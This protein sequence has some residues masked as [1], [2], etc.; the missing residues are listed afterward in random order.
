MTF[1]LFVF[2]FKFPIK[3]YSKELQIATFFS[4][5]KKIR[6]REK[7]FDEEADASKQARGV[8]AFDFVFLPITDM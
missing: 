3:F 8:R 7:L 2:S 1:L 6:G 4:E 5:G